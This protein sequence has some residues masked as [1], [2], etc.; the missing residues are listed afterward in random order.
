MLK[1]KEIPLFSRLD[2]KYMSELQS[3]MLIRSYDK[4]SLVFY[5]GETSE[6]LYILLEGD[7]RVYKTTPKGSQ[8]HMHNFSAPEIIALIAIFEEIPFPASCE[9]L[10]EG[11]VGLLSMSKIKK[12]MQN[13]DFSISLVSALTKR[14]K[15]LSKLLHKETVYS[16]EAKIADLIVRNKSI[17]E[18]LK[19]NEIASI[20]NMTP[21]TFSRI[22]TKLKRKKFITIDEHIVKIHN[23]NALYSIIDTNSI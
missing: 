2:E 13:A 4:N 3:Q 20:L 12:C 18:H 16:S 23:E 15:L 11:K 19:N 21:E 22:L 14:M 17:F 9:F 1:L 8:I 10:T 7:V 5:E 6:Y